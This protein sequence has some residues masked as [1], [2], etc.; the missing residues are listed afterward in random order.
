MAAALRRAF[1]DGLPSKRPRPRPW[2]QDAVHDSDVEVVLPSAVRGHLLMQL[3]AK[4]AALGWSGV[5]PELQRALRPLALIAEQLD[6]GERDVL[7][8]LVAVA[9]SEVSLHMGLLLGNAQK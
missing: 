2:L 9:C 8:E 7:L 3:Q 6:A 4:A 1:G 5:P